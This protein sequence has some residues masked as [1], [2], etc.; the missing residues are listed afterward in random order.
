L[1]TADIFVSSLQSN[2]QGSQQF[3][4]FSGRDGGGGGGDGYRTLYI[5]GGVGGDY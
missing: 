4:V 3:L 2:Q 1:C 5:L